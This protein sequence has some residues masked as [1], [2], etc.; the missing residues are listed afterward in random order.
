MSNMVFAIF[1]PHSI[2]Q[3]RSDL[4]RRKVIFQSS[5]N[6]LNVFIIKY[7]IFYNGHGFY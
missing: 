6:S 5:V 2:G 1:E 3:H 7:V 4:L